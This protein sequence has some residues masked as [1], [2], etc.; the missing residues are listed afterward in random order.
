M[1]FFSSEISTDVLS[2]DATTSAQNENVVEK[3]ENAIKAKPTI[4]I[5]YDFGENERNEIKTLKDLLPHY[6]TV[7]PCLKGSVNGMINLD[8]DVVKPSRSG[9]D[10]L[11]ERFIKNVVKKTNRSAKEVR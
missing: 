10:E 6:S 3:P 7:K 5:D 11:L 9:G 8:V 1:R 2:E 4:E